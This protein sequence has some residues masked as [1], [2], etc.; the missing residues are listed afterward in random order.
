MFL[1]FYVQWNVQKQLQF[2]QYESDQA[3]EAKREAEFLRETL[4]NMQT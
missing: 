2:L 1:S 3:K 4:D